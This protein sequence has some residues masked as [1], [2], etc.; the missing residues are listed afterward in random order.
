MTPS[1]CDSEDC[2]SGVCVTTAFT[3]LVTSMVTLLV[4]FND[5][6]FEAHNTD[7]YRYPGSWSTQPF[8]YSWLF[9]GID[10]LKNRGSIHDQWSHH[11]FIWSI[12]FILFSTY[13]YYCT[14]AL[15]IL[16]TVL[17]KYPLCIGSFFFLFLKL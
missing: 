13:V 3:T 16:R 10:L 11:L 17:T 6:K 9:L 7:R 1:W 8:L 5:T 4:N 2:W 15:C 14:F 12:H